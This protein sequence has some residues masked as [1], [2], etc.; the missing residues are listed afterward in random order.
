MMALSIEEFDVSAHHPGAPRSSR[1]VKRAGFANTTAVGTQAHIAPQS[2]EWSGD[3]K[4]AGKPV[5]RERASLAQS[6]P[7]VKR[8]ARTLNPRFVLSVAS[9]LPRRRLFDMPVR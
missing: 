1:R 7:V 6:T 9:P 3:G 2:G 4:V 8:A 5:M